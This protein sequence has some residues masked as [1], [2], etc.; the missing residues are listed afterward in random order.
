MEVLS[1]EDLIAKAGDL[2]V[3]PFVAKK[4]LEAVSDHNVTIETLCSIIEKDQTIAARVLKISNSA[5]YGLR[6]EVTSLNQAVMVLGLRTIRSLV[7]SVSTKSLYRTFGMTEK[8]MWEHSVGA[9]VASRLISADF[10]NEM[11]EVAFT[12]GLMHDLGKIFMNNETPKAFSQTMMNIYNEHMDSIE[13]EKDVYGFIHPEI[14]AAVVRK[15]GLSPMTAEIIAH[16]HL[17]DTSL[18]SIREPVAAKGVATVHLANHVCKVLG[19]GYRTPDASIVLHDL[20]S[21]RF[22]GINKDRMESLA[23]Q[24]GDMFASEKSLF[25]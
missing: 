20:P 9:A 4:L 25:D 7:L 12:G 11:K 18:E 2:N 23:A 16:H 17:Q 15:W 24:T 19:I 14:G 3:L 5:L 21:A 10:G 1:R 8:M 13:A 22:L 6:Q